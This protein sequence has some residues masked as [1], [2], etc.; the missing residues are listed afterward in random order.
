MSKISRELIQARRRQKLKAED[1]ARSTGINVNIIKMIEAGFMYPQYHMLKRFS[2]VYGIDLDKLTSMNKPNSGFN[3]YLCR[4]N[5]HFSLKLNIAKGTILALLVAFVALIANLT[6]IATNV[7]QLILPSVEDTPSLIKPVFFYLPLMEEPLESYPNRYVAY[8]DQCRNNYEF[9]KAIEYMDQGLNYELEKTTPNTDNIHYIKSSLG[10]LHFIIG[11]FDN[12]IK[13]YSEVLLLVDKDSVQAGRM[14]YNLGQIYSQKGERDKAAD[15]YAQAVNQLYDSDFMISLLCRLSSIQIS[16]ENYEIAHKF[17]NDALARSNYEEL[18]VKF[19]RGEATTIEER[20]LIETTIALLEYNQAIS[21]LEDKTMENMADI[22]IY[23]DSL[24]DLVTL[25]ELDI[26]TKINVY[27]IMTYNYAYIDDFEEAERMNKECDQLI[28]QYL[29]NYHMAHYQVDLS[30]IWV[31]TEQGN[32]R[33]ARLAADELIQY[34]LSQGNN[35]L[36]IFYELA[37][38]FIDFDNYYA[39]YT[40]ESL[41]DRFLDFEVSIKKHYYIGETYYFHVENPNKAI[42]HFSEAISIANES[43]TSTDYS[44]GSSFLLCKA[45][46]SANQYVAALLECRNFIDHYDVRYEVPT[47]EIIDSQN[48][49]EAFE[50]YGIDEND[51]KYYEFKN[52]VGY[53]IHGVIYNIYLGCGKPKESFKAWWQDAYN[54]NPPKD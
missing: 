26:L 16:Y 29:P 37:Y 5:S 13:L 21:L 25:F 40:L 4:W 36:D 48:W 49:K 7:H 1:I 12:A 35:D 6:T 31:L 32:I 22:M 27:N 53:S 15:Y 42:E 45:Y 19:G 47:Y 52:K 34:L 11:D 54:Q 2:N 50:H 18:V 10:S 33:D 38:M 44:L 39:I 41:E 51:Y 43:N 17:L 9:E 46:Y 3:Q 8:A 30:R 24:N 14:R 28:D 20:R 23:N